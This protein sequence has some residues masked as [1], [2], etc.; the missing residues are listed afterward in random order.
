MARVE[1]QV[2]TAQSSISVRAHTGVEKELIG[3]VDGFTTINGSIS[4]NNLW[5]DEGRRRQGIGT[6]MLKRVK[7]WGEEIGA[8]SIIA[9]FSPDPNV[10]PEG[11]IAF[12]N[13][14]GIIID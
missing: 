14:N 2:E 6:E 10:D 13:Q 4:L 7:D 11:V 5:V 8:R 9:P 1:Y 12:Y 3:H